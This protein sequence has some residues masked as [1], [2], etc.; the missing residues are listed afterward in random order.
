MKFTTFT[1][2]REFLP[3]HGE[4]RITRQSPC[5]VIEIRRLACSRAALLEGRPAT[6][7]SMNASLVVV[8]GETIQLAMEVDAVPEERFGVEIDKD[9]VRRVL[10]KHCWPTGGSDS[11]SWLT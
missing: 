4:M 10:V 7:S 2:K 8:D 1:V 6:Q 9:V 11:P 5:I 3:D